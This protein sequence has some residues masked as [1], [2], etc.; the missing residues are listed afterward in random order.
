MAFITNEENPDLFDSLTKDTKAKVNKVADVLADQIAERQEIEDEELKSKTAIRPVA[1]QAY[2]EANEDNYGAQINHTFDFGTDLQV[3]FVNNYVIRDEDH[4]AEILELLGAN[5]P[6]TEHLE[7]SV[8]VVTNVTELYDQ[9]P[10]R[11]K[12]YADELSALN[13]RYGLQSYV[14]EE[15]GVDAEFHN[16]RHELLTAEDNQELDKILPVQVQFTLKN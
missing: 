13:K 4:V 5:H 6:L 16:A 15:F 9:N 10:K 12:A 11:Y 7:Q 14:E 3:N 2:F 1:K 8:E